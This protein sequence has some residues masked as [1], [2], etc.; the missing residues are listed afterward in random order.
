[1][2]DPID[3]NL[4]R[5]AKTAPE[6]EWWKWD[7][8]TWS[9]IIS[10]ILGDEETIQKLEC[11]VCGKKK[12]YAY[13]L[14]VDIAAQASN[15]EGRPVYIAD[16]W[17]GCYACQTQVRDRGELPQWVKDKDIRWASEDLKKSAERRLT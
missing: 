16:R 13:F 12:L 9:P 10:Q 4:W 7:W 14:A 3:F 2:N 5:R 11:P 15:K 17:F 6:S 8:D 1:M